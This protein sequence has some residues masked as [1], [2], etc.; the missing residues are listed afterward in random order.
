MQ[1]E[2]CDCATSN[3]NRGDLQCNN[4]QM[5]NFMPLSPMYRLSKYLR[6]CISIV[7]SEVLV[8]KVFPPEIFRE[9]YCVT[10]KKSALIFSQ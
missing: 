1:C 3:G 2:E 8:Y 9:N 5:P 6:L 10:G 4:Q 7:E